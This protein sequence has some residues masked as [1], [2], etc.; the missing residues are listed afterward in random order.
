MLRSFYTFITVAMVAVDD[1]VKVLPL[2]GWPLQPMSCKGVLGLAVVGVPAAAVVSKDNKTRAMINIVIGIQLMT[3][4]GLTLMT[5]GRDDE[6]SCDALAGDATVVYDGIA[7][8]L[9]SLWLSAL[10]F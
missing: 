9:Q 2:P 7:L 10:L 6:D 5:M 3:K 4:T 1:V 8:D